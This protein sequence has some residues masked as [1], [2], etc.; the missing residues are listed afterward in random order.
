VTTTPNPEQGPSSAA[1]DQHVDQG[2]GVGQG[3]GEAGPTDDQARE[4]G[5][6]AAVE[7][8]PAELSS[9]GDPVPDNPNISL[10]DREPARS[11]DDLPPGRPA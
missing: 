2:P 6:S 9:E 8:G 1:D 10:E 3:L 7:R 11:I 4:V 5:V